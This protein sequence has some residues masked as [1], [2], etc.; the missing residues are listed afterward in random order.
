MALFRRKKHRESVRVAT[1]NIPAA[2]GQSVDDGVSVSDAL[3]LFYYLM[4]ADGTLH[5]DE[6]EKF[7]AIYEEL[8]GSHHVKQE[9]LI[10]ECQSRLDLAPS[11]VDPIVSAF[12]CVDHVLYRPTLPDGQGFTVPPKLLV[13]DLLAIAYSD[14][15]CHSAERSLIS[16]IASVVGLD[17]AL[18]LEMESFV[19]TLIDLDQEESWIKTTAQ[20]YLVIESVLADIESRKAAAL[21]GAKA[22]IA[23]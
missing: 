21:D 10:R 20:P 19:L 3:S 4:A 6:L 15:S 22:L 8:D 23:F 13:W 1:E 9:F 16:H 18:V 14:G 17:D 7:D 2:T 12:A 11:S 5:E